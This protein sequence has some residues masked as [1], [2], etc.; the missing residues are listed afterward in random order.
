MILDSG[1]KS[2]VY[3]MSDG[4]REN[5]NLDVGQ[6]LLGKGISQLIANADV[7]FSNSMV[8]AVFRQL[9][10]KAFNSLPRSKREIHSRIENFVNEYNNQIPHSSLGGETPYEKYLGLWDA[11]SFKDEIKLRRINRMKQRSAEHRQCGQCFRQ[12]ERS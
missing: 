9:K 3:M 4:G 1:F 8:E 10:Q 5:R 2:P 7:Y 12:Q 6:Y 11:E